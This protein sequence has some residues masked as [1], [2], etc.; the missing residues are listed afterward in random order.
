MPVPLLQIDA[1]TSRA[2]A[3][4]PAAVCWLEQP[5][6][7]VWMQQVASEMNLSETAFLQPHP[8]GFGLRWF[9]PKVEVD[10]CGHATL[11]AARALEEWGRLQPGQ[12]ARFLTRSGWLTAQRSGA[13]IELDFPARLSAPAPVPDGLAA[14]LGHVQPVACSLGGG[15][16]GENCL[17]ELE[18]AA[19]VRAAQ[20]DFPALAK[21]AL[22]SVV[23]TAAGD[24][25][26]DFTSRFFAP[27][28]GVNEDP[29]TGSAHTQLGPYWGAKLRRN[30]LLAYQASARGGEMRLGLR[31]ERIR[32]A[33]EA[34]LVLRGELTAD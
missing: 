19:A 20:P 22:R 33:G 13:W 5:R 23:I 27:A 25:P 24:P 30:R 18:S 9:T 3:G 31:G 2:F 10:L 17:L 34:V 14:A 1:F 29:V 26:Y 16:V 32:L 7:A 6:P 8:E 15:P 28:A 11:A 21:L 4:N 12:T